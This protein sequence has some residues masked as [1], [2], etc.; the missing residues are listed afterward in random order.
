MEKTDIFCGLCKKDKMMSCE[1]HFLTP[2]FVFH[3]RHISWWFS[4]KRLC[5]H[6]Q[7]RDI[8]AEFLFEFFWH[9]KICLK[10]ILK[11]RSTC[12]HVPKRHSREQLLIYPETCSTQSKSWKK[13][14]QYKDKS[15]T[16]SVRKYLSD[17]WIKMNVSQTKIHLDTS[18]FPTSISGR[19]EYIIYKIL[20][21]HGY[22]SYGTIAV[23]ITN[24][25]TKSKQIEVLNFWHMSY[26][27]IVCVCTKR[28]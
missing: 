5:E 9:F 20:R 24:L 21:W 27:K 18:I 10:Y 7:Y 8:R 19:R 26:I 3:T 23:I 22:S 25:T 15:T 16:P 6:I 4:A 11:T 12:S 1:N 17:K 2:N 28:G 14:K 13:G